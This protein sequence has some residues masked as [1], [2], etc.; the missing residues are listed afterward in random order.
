M[1][2][3]AKFYKSGFDETTK[4]KL[5]IFEK[6][7]KVWLPVFLKQSYI[8]CVQIF[9]FFAGRGYDFKEN[10]G[11]PIITLK[12][13]NSYY[14]LFSQSGVKAKLFL[15][16]KD[17]KIYKDLKSNCENYLNSNQKLSSIVKIK[18]YNNDFKNI[19]PELKKEIE[20]DPGKC[21]NLIFLDQYG[22]RYVKWVLEFDKFEHT[23]FLIF[24][25]S[26]SLKRFYNT[27]EFRNALNLSD[28]DVKM[29]KNT[30]YKMIHEAVLQFLKSKLPP[31]SK[32]KLYPFSLKKNH[33]IYGLIFGSKHILA[34]DKFLRIVWKI[35]GVNGS[36]N[37]DIYDDEEKN[38]P[39]LFPEYIGKTS[40]QIFEDNLEIAIRKGKIKTNKDVYFYTLERGYLPK[41]AVKVLKKLKESGIIYYKRAP[42]VDYKYVCGKK[43]RIIEYEKNEN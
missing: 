38:K 9:D 25:S 28:K 2:K 3:N 8:K 21:P 37:Y 13:I 41:H 10:P 16:E 32:L 24:V 22:V 14:D 11:S 7:L 43:K 29:L 40:L 30:P 15:N 12:Q 5:D 19:F 33:N 6:Y 27:K 39:N 20:K 23:D 4:V 17:K 18:Y 34:V 42:L 26:S 36:A 35:N 31:D 1:A